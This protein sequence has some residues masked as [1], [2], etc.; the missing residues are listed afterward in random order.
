MQSKNKARDHA[1]DSKG[2]ALP[3]VEI[4]Q[5]AESSLLAV[6][7]FFQALAEFFRYRWLYTG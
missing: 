7:R 5:V 2:W 4:L 1:F 3:G 6:R